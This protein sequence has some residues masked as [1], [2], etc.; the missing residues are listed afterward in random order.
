MGE[1]DAMESRYGLANAPTPAAPKAKG[2]GLDV[3]ELERAYG[4]KPAGAPA[5]DEAGFRRWYGG[6]AQKLK[7][8]AV[9]CVYVFNQQGRFEKKFVGEQVDYKVIEAEVARLLKK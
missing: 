5:F 7:I 2:K 4:V 9:P 1:I 3:D 6:V 8:D